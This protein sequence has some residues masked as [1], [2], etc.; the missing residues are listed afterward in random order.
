MIR[1]PTPVQQILF[2]STLRPDLRAEATGWSAEDPSQCFA[3]PDVRTHDQIGLIPGFRGSYTYQAPLFALADGWKLLA[4][5][6]EDGTEWEWWFVRDVVTTE[7]H[8]ES[9]VHDAD[10]EKGERR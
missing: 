6:T 10:S 2:M 7:L 8:G 4:P 3:R 5:P 1:L 9:Q